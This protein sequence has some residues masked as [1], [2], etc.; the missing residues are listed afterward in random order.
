[1][2]GSSGWVNRALFIFAIGALG[3][4]LMIAGFV[5]ILLAIDW[6]SSVTWMS[7]A[8]I[9]ALVLLLVLFTGGIIAG[10]ISLVRWG[11]RRSKR[12]EM[13]RWMAERQSGADASQIRWRNRGIRWASWLPS[14]IVLFVLSFL[15]E[16][17][18]ILSHVA[19]PRGATVGL[20]HVSVPITWILLEC[21]EGPGRD[22]AYT[23]GLAGR[24]IAFDSLRYLRNDAPLSEWNIWITESQRSQQSANHEWALRRGEITGRHDF[25][26]GEESVTC[27]EYWPAYLQRP[28][29][30]ASS[31]SV[32]VDC[33]GSRRL[34]ASL[35]GERVHLASFYRMLEGIHM[36]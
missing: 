31:G 7:W 15:P 20:C 28:K 18:G 4:P 5:A 3:V 27:V 12:I 25:S 14:A 21:R 2:Y 32:F 13:T 6:I 30:T 8:A 26:I 16:T 19:N 29:Q 33:I 36:K 34:S 35:V 22:E 10:L 9:V 23:V 11:A 24:G 1:M 17:W